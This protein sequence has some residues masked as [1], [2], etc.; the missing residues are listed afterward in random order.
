M[1]ESEMKKPYAEYLCATVELFDV[2]VLLCV[3]DKRECAKL[4]DRNRSPDYKGPK[5]GGAFLEGVDG[6]TGD[7]VACTFFAKP[8]IFIYAPK[9]ITLSTLVHETSHAVDLI[10]ETVGFRDGETRAWCMEKVFAQLAPRYCKSVA[11]PVD[12]K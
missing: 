4:V 1:E 10:E 11:K 12:G 5:V 6:T 8:L 9:P 2:Q 3:G 7:Y